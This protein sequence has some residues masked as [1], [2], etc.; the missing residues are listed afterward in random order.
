[1]ENNPSLININ[2]LAKILNI[3]TRSISRLVRDGKIPKPVHL[4]SMIRWNKDKIT[5]W[6]D[7]GCP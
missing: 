2:E 4:N 5:K 3:S 6:L 7:R 1:M